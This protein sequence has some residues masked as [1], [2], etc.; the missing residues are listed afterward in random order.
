MQTIED[1][2]QTRAPISDELWAVL[3]AEDATEGQP[4][5]AFFM[6]GEEY[7]LHEADGGFFPH[8][9]WYR[10]VR[11]ETREEAEAVL[12]EWRKEWVDEAA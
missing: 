6:Y 1:F 11:K 3:Q 8:A 4:R 12:W 7:V 5:E 10:P 9:W 2:R